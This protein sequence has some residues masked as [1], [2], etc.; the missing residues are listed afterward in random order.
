MEKIEPE[1][2]KLRIKYAKESS[3]FTDIKIIWLTFVEI[4]KVVFLR[5]KSR[6]EQIKNFKS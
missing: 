3:F 4:I 6:G 5:K 2:N 1:K